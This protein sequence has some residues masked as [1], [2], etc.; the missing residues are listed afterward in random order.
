MSEPRFQAHAKRAFVP[1]LWPAACAGSW[2]F[3]MPLDRWP[4]PISFVLAYL[5]IG[6]PLAALGAWLRRP[7]LGLVAGL[8][9]LAV[10]LHIILPLLH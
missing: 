10:F 3:A 1:A 5:A 9:A 6:G 8:I 7:W 2:A 4:E